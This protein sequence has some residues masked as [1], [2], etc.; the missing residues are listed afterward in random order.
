MDEP[1]MIGKCLGQSDTYSQYLF[2]MFFSVVG[3]KISKIYPL[4]KLR[5]PR[6]AKDF[7]VFLRL[8]EEGR[9]GGW[10]HLQTWLVTSLL[11]TTLDMLHPALFIITHHYSSLFHRLPGG[12]L[13]AGLFWIVI[14]PQKQYANTCKTQFL[15]H[16]I[17][18]LENQVLIC[19]SANYSPGLI[20]WYGSPV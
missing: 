5:R 17:Y 13:D 6:H 7:Q 1:C 10:L 16:R 12:I 2:T 4:A 15:V 9:P 3:A 19:F 8:L 18:E 14:E 11:E 20:S